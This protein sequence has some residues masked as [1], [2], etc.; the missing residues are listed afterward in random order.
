MTETTNE[1]PEPK[2][3]VVGASSTRADAKAKA[4]G[5][6][7]YAADNYPEGVLW[8]GAVRP[9]ALQGVVHA[10]LLGIDT[11]AAA[12]LPGREQDPDPPPTFPERT[13]RESST[14]TCRCWSATS[15]ATPAIRSRW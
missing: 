1:L 2:A 9:G 4:Q 7:P 12:A 6:E 15:C 5:R 10:R 3:L 14:R 11:A 8:A 13:A